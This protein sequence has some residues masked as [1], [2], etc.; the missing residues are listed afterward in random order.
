MEYTLTKIH[1]FD[2]DGTLTGRDT[3]LEFIRFAKGGKFLLKC[4]LA[5]LPQ[6]VA[7][8][9][10]LKDNGKVKESVFA[11]CFKGMQL[12]DFNDLCVNFASTNARLLRPAGM[13]H[14]RKVMAEGC[15]VVVVS[16]SIDNWVRPFFSGING[17]TVI[18]TMAEER[19]GILTGRFASANC[20]GME[21]VN[22]LKN[23]F[24][25]IRSYELTAYGDSR[26]DMEML[27]F[28]DRGYYK[29]FRNGQH[30]IC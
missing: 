3:L 16:A 20:Y 11:Y 14:L 1:V 15:K 23:L 18:A 13:L 4:L 21:K 26:G 8:K 2:F 12:N 24:P 17:V 10:G 25:D 29:P 6:L 9:L 5:H 30:E 27:D 28:A 22:R 7:M 19:D